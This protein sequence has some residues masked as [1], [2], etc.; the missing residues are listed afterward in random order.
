MQSLKDLALL[1]SEKKQM[2]KF[3]FFINKEICQL[4]PLNIYEN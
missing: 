2:L 1:L 3:G 4:S